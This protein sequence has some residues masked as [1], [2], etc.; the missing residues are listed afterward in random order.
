MTTPLKPATYELGLTMNTSGLKPDIFRLM[1]LVVF[2]YSFVQYS[3]QYWRALSWKQ[4]LKRF[5]EKH[6]NCYKYKCQQGQKL[7]RMSLL[8]NTT[9]HVKLFLIL[10]QQTWAC[11]K[12][13]CLQRYN[14]TLIRHDYPDDKPFM[15]TWTVSA[16]CVTPLSPVL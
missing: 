8:C 6:F 13:L 2:V 7:L 12:P 15:F 11:A 10:H 4:A 14:V 1:F 3:Q 9:I 5:K 16:Q